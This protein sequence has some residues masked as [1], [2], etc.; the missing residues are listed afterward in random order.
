MTEVKY[1]LDL[2]SKPC[3]GVLRYEN[4]AVYAFEDG[5]EV[6]SHSLENVGELV[7]YTMSDAEASRYRRLR[8]SS[9]LIMTVPRISPSAA[10]P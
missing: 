6:F 8:M 1:D 3:R 10:S 2:N 4:G 9:A 7:Q 5:R